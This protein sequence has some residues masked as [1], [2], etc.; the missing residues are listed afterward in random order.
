MIGKLYFNYIQMTCFEVK[1]QN[2]C[3]ERTF[4]GRC[5]K[6]KWLKGAFF[7][8]EYRPYWIISKYVNSLLHCL[9]LSEWNP[10]LLCRNCLII[11][12]YFLTSLIFLIK[13]YHLLNS[14]AK[15]CF[16]SRYIAR[17]FSVLE[18]KYGD[19]SCGL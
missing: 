6:K 3:V 12:L 13:M 2:I 15:F 7:T 19:C 8:N 14:V 16:I 4:W 10:L 17:V 1:K 5:L 9:H 18:I 11:Y